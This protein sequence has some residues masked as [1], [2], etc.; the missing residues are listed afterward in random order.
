VTVVE[1]HRVDVAAGKDF[2][3]GNVG[4]ARV[5]DTRATDLVTKPVT[6]NAPVKKRRCDAGICGYVS[7]FPRSPQA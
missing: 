7:S 4:V 2:V 1:L 6:E 3:N 5:R